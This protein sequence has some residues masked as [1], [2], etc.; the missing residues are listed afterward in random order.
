MFGREGRHQRVFPR[1]PAGILTPV[2]LPVRREGM[3]FLVSC[4]SSYSPD[5]ARSRL[6]YVQQPPFTSDGAAPHSCRAAQQCSACQSVRK[7]GKGRVG[8]HLA[9]QARPP[10]L[11]RTFGRLHLLQRTG[12]G[13]G[14]PYNS[15]APPS[16]SIIWRWGLVLTTYNSPTCRAGRQDKTENW[17]K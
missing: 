12:G 14:V 9:A 13:R 17:E 2:V 16:H 6:F 4:L 10:E 8:G 7:N 15:F 11:H 1:G 5:E 3:S